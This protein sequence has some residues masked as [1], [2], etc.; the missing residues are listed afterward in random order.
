M[1]PTNQNNPKEGETL[2]DIVAVYEEPGSNRP[3]SLPPV[4]AKFCRAAEGGAEPQV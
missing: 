3:P 1:S 2:A 4:G